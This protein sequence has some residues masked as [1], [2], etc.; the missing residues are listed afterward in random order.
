MSKLRKQRDRC[1]AL[2]H[3]EFWY[4]NW[5]FCCCRLDCK[6]HTRPRLMS[7]AFVFVLRAVPPAAA[8]AALLRYQ[9]E[10]EVEVE[11]VL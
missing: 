11:G 2:F 1:E 6:G 8:A 4:C 5:V 7:F 10:V 9:V 3:T